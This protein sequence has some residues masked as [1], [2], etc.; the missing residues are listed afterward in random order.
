MVLHCSIFQDISMLRFSQHCPSNVSRIRIGYLGCCSLFISIYILHS[1]GWIKFHLLLGWV[2][3]KLS[4]T[5]SLSILWL[6]LLENR[7]R[8]RRPSPRF[9][10]YIFCNRC[11]IPLAFAEPT[12]L[13]KVLALITPGYLFIFAVPAIPIENSPIRQ[14]GSARREASNSTREYY[15]Y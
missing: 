7:Q 12:S 3:G 11:C 13:C 15:R 1:H 5:V 6:F 14:M 10:H 8:C 2:L 4:I 9:C